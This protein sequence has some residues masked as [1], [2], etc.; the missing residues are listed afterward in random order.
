MGCRGAKVDVPALKSQSLTVFK[1]H[2]DAY[3][4]NAA[5]CRDNDRPS[6]TACPSHHI[7]NPYKCPEWVL[8]HGVVKRVKA[9]VLKDGHVIFPQ[10]QL[11]AKG[12]Y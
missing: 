1:L 12:T 8:V 11:K 5:P 3:F 6:E 9:F 7:L 2:N 4:F 10:L